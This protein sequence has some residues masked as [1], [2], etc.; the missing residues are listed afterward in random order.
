MNFETGGLKFFKLVMIYEYIYFFYLPDP[1]GLVSS[2]HSRLLCGI[3]CETPKR[4]RDFFKY[5]P[6]VFQIRIRIQSGQLS[7]ETW[8]QSCISPVQ[9]PLRNI[10]LRGHEK[11]G[12]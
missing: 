12:A 5:L 4:K 6:P 3:C 11:D 10:Y 2:S 1:D 9:A 7:L 8:I